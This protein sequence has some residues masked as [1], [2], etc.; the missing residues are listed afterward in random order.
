MRCPQAPGPS[1]SEGQAR[2][3]WTAELPEGRG[4]RAAALGRDSETAVLSLVAPRPVCRP[5][6]TGAG[7]TLSVSAGPS[8]NVLGEARLHD[9]THL[10][11]DPWDPRFYCFLNVIKFPRR[12]PV[13]KS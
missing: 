12:Q 3:S 6:V 1:P 5:A 10:R 9:G 7:L 13:G 11:R 2:L 8:A 4:E